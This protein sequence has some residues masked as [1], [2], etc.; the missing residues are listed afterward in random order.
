M[1]RKVD[2]KW[3][4]LILIILHVVGVFGLISPFQSLFL[5]L[6]PINLLISAWFLLSKHQQ[7]RAKFL[8]AFVLIAFTIGFISEVLGVNYGLIF[9]SYNYGP[10][11]G[12]KFLEVPFM[13]G[14]NWVIVMYCS[15][16]IAE[17]ISGNRILQIVLAVLLAVLL[18]FVMEPIAIHF[19]FWTWSDHDIPSSNYL[20]WSAIA[21]L[22]AGIF[23]ALK[24]RAD[25]PLA[26]PLFVIQFL[27]FLI[28]GFLV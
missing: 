10:V 1:I 26:I 13:I 19:N 23:K 28:L 7:L 8:L 24:L 25:N 2:S 5:T 3:L 9:G 18:D 6:T 16:A 11:L 14:V 12:P 20:G 21:L 27:F 22:I 15:L 4:I 17:K